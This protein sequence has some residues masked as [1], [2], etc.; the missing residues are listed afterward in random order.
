M[1]WMPNK[2]L[3]AIGGKAR[4]SLSTDVQRP[5]NIDNLR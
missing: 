5:E 1:K 3:Q 4:L 2:A